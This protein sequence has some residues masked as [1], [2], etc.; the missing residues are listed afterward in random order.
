MTRLWRQQGLSHTVRL[1]IAG[2]RTMGVRHVLS[3]AANAARQVE[4]DQRYR[5]WAAQHPWTDDQAARLRADIATLPYRPTIS[6]VTAVFN[7]EPAWLLRAA[8][9]V[10]NQIYPHWQLCLCDDGSTRQ[11]TI[12]ALETLRGSAG[13]R[14]IRLDTN[15]GISQASN[16]ALSLA[17]GE[18]V[19]FLD[20]DDE[21]TKDALA[22]VVKALNG[23]P[24]PDIVYSD[25]DKIDE[26]GVLSQ[27]HFKPDWSP[28][29]LLS[30]MY[31]SHFTVM[32]RQLVVDAGAFRTGFEG[33]QDYDLLLRATER[34]SR[35][36][37]VPRVL[38]HW[39][40]APESAASSQLSKPWAVQAAE[41]ALTDHL[42]RHGG[43]DVRS[44]G[45]AGHFR[46]QFAIPKPPLVSVLV[47][48]V[49]E[50]AALQQRLARTRYRAV[51]VLSGDTAGPDIAACLNVLAGKA[52][53]EHLL[54][55]DPGFEPA[56][57][58]WLTT[59]VELS[60]R[61][62]VGAAGPLLLGADGRIESAGIVIGTSECVSPAFAGEPAWARGHLSNLHDV[63]NVSALP[64][65]VFLTS[66]KAFELAG[67]FCDG[68]GLALFT[69]DYGLR[70]RR[71]GL[72]TAITPHARLRRRTGVSAPGPTAS[73]CARLREIWGAELDNDP[74]YNAHFDRSSATFR[75]PGGTKG[76]TERK[77]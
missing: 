2:V 61:T 56:D 68:L 52:T 25:E 19:G 57:P 21:L 75:L 30:C 31:A 5:E 24:Q 49:F 73:E 51:E 9:S 10:Q 7:T 26:H 59:L 33:S 22:E 32:R 46:V 38:Y 4:D 41:R 71:A 1:A 18:F 58:S 43:G 60:M 65:S 40:T 42:A 16:A 34:S 17:T 54:V 35:V 66:R 74:Y 8:A 28:E 55:L 48:G 6:I 62:G 13:V 70:T 37:H 64:A 36:A 29:L 47:P 77:A 23:R 63:R 72:R 45:P 44:A 20:H 53:G 67:G 3:R 50:S 15:S 39:R 12:A 14:V 76:Q 11:D 69:V 27:P